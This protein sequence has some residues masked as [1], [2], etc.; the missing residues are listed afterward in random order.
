MPIHKKYSLILFFLMII[1]MLFETLGVGLIIPI[2]SVLSNDT[3]SNKPQYLLSAYKFLNYPSQSK[4]ILFAMSFMVIIYFIK[5]VY[6]GFLSWAQFRFSNTLQVYFSQRLFSIY[7]YQPYSFHLNNNSA[8]LSRNVLTEVGQ[9]QAA[10]TQLMTLASEFLVIIGITTLLVSTEPIG[11]I[12]VFIILGGVS[13]LFNKITKKKISRWGEE[14]LYHT[15]QVNQQLL[16]GLAGV[17]DI[18]VLGREKEFLKTFL[19]HQ[20]KRA[21][22]DRLYA[23]ISNLPKLWLEFL[24]ILALSLLVIIMVLQNKPTSLILPTLS[25]FA[26]ASFRLMPSINKILNAFQGFSYSKASIEMIYGELQLNNNETKISYTSHTNINFNTN[27]IFKNITYIYPNTIL[28]AL[29]NCTIEIKKGQTIGIIGASGSGKSTL[30]DLFLGLLKP[31][32]G[33]LL[34]DDFNINESKYNTRCWQDKIGYINQSIYL[35]DDTLRKNIALGIADNL[36]NEDYIL[37]SLK[38]AQLDDFINSLPEGLNTMV[39][40]RGVRLSGGQRQRIGIARALYHN[41]PVLVL[42]EATSALDQHTE[43]G[44]MESVKMLTGKTI[45]IVAHRYST[46]EHCDWIFKLNNGKLVEQGKAEVIISKQ[47]I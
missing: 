33:E 15:G 5:N 36:I 17:K 35:T 18:K 32:R 47:K 40:E 23:V 25:L 9:F 13:W 39:G 24:G 11:S 45:I 10:I 46:I 7:M 41:P 3:N 43:H 16:Q 34:I 38:L 1:G 22:V 14:R 30:V 37:N 21:Y 26:I 8:I 6:L 42:D 12:L 2:F 28:P 27:I 31:T 4:I 44:V 29:E 19:K 20:T